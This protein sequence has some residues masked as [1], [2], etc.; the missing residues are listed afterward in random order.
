M[1]TE[2]GLEDFLFNAIAQDLN[3]LSQRG[4]PM[5]YHPNFYRQVKLGDYGV[6]DIL[7]IGRNKETDKLEIY[8]YELK[9]DS[10]GAINIPQISK[11]LGAVDNW[12][13]EH[14]PIDE[15]YSLTGFLMAPKFDSFLS[16][17]VSPNIYF[18]SI[19]YDPYKGVRFEQHCYAQYRSV[20]CKSVDIIIP[21]QN[22]YD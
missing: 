14:N 21:K 11:Y 7:A 5:P 16:Y 19:E 4:F 1:M 18:Y 15:V 3:E 20:D 9:R 13:S 8:L 2:K 12:L 17:F 10:V 22:L 6:V